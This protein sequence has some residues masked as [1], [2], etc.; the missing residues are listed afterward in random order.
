MALKMQMAPR[1]AISTAKST[2]LGQK[3]STWVRKMSRRKVR[4]NTNIA[5]TSVKTRK[6]TLT[7]KRLIPSRKNISIC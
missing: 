6:M 3:L 2:T 5:T 1:L 4:E 7:I